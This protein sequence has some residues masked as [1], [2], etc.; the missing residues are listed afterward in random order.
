MRNFGVISLFPDSVKSYFDSS[1]LKRAQE[2]SL[3][4]I[5][6]FQP[7]DYS[8]NLYD[9]IDQKPYGGGPGMV[10]EAVP[11]IRAWEDCTSNFNNPKTIFFSPSGKQFKQADAIEFANSD[12]DIIF[13]CGRYEGID[14]RVKEITNAITYTV[15]P[16]VLTGGELPA[17]IMIDAISRHLNGVLGDNESIEE[18]RISSAS[19][20]TRP[21]HLEYKG[22]TYSVPPVLLSGNHAEIDK[23][24]LNND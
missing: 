4:N 24:R 21:E 18:N 6:Y 10:L 16:Y 9:R 19:V 23:W 8:D 7:R 14:E 5:S 1:I 22:K 11:F 12:S 15:G 20:Y 3:I 2:D 13:I 17:A